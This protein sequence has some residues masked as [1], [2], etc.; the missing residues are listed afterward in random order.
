MDRRRGLLLLLP[1]ICGVLLFTCALSS[2]PTRAASPDFVTT[3]TPPVASPAQVAA[4][5]A[6]WLESSH[7]DTYD[8]GVGANTTC[9][10][11][12]SPT[13]WDPLS[14]TADLSLDCYS[15]KHVPG[16]PRPELPS[17]DP[18]NESNWADISC[19][20][21][22]E[23]VGDS[24][25]TGIAY[26]DQPSRSY[27]PVDNVMELCAHCHEGQHGFEV[28]E[29][30]RESPI[31]TG[32]ECTECHGSH[33]SPSACTDCHN[34]LEGPGAPEHERHPDVN[35]TACHDSGALTIHRDLDPGSKHFNTYI[36]VRFA[37]SLTSWPSHDLT[38]DI[39]CVRCHH[40]GP[41]GLRPVDT[42][43]G[44]S[45]CHP[46]GAMWIWCTNFT[47]DLNPTAAHQ[48]Y[49]AGE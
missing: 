11:C 40:P 8:M 32:W 30:Q 27:L 37:H 25:S 14:D 26:W 10:R 41:T 12:K 13:N 42:L 29:E 15:C 31:H 9:A 22:H 5:K 49:G 36:P 43:T 38:T 18:V 1:F 28:I 46:D 7:S 45:A 39:N 24:F 44:C 47:R 35:C 20:I 4:A 6:E 17:G 3:A 16:E 23:P 21:C 19:E 2:A 48:I 33:G 34:P